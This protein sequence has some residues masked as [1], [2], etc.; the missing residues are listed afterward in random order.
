MRQSSST[1]HQ[2]TANGETFSVLISNSFRP[3]GKSFLPRDF[4]VA[5]LEEASAVHLKGDSPCFPATKPETATVPQLR[6]RAQKHGRA[7]WL[8]GASE[9]SLFAV[10]WWR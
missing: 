2:R 4:R 1:R 3:R 8:S 5:R 9:F 6:A 7:I 10:C